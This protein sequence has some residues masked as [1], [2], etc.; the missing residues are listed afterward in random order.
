MGRRAHVQR[1][2][3]WLNGMPVGYWDAIAGEHALTYFD[4]WINDQQGRP[5]SLSLPFQPG[6]A[7]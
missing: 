1:L 4:D 7:A 5:L 6:N 3:I 2:N